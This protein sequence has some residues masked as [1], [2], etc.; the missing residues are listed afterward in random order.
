MPI[1]TAEIEVEYRGDPRRSTHVS[2][3]MDLV[4]YD[5]ETRIIG[6]RDGHVIIVD[7][8]FTLSLSPEVLFRALAEWRSS[9][10]SGDHTDHYGA[11]WKCAEC[12]YWFCFAEG[13]DNDPELCD[14]CWSKKHDKE[15]PNAGACFTPAG[16]A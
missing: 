12:G 9:V 2:P 5:E 15:R 4:F 8:G 6:A 1:I 13:T 3:H 10:C 16:T 7:L 14:S 11:L